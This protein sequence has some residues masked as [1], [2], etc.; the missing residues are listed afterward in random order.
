M[1]EPMREQVLVA[2]AARLA[3]ISEEDGFYTTPKQIVT[4]GQLLPIDRYNE[5]PVILLAASS[6]TTITLV[7]QKEAYLDLFTFRT[8]GYVKGD[9]VTAVT[10]RRERLWDDVVRRIL[11]QPGLGGLCQIIRPLRLEV[12][13]TVLDPFGAFVQYWQAQLVQPFRVAA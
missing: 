1:P 8:W 2:I 10:T 5:F 12:D 3:G 6:E 7:A 13:E 11:Q 9:D 4:R